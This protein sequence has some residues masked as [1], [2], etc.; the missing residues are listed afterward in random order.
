MLFESLDGIPYYYDA[1]SNGIFAIDRHTRDINAHIEAG[2]IPE[3]LIKDLLAEGVPFPVDQKMIVLEDLEKVRGM[4]ANDMRN[5][6]LNVTEECNFRCGYC[7]YSGNY[8]YERTHSGNSMDLDTAKKAIDMFASRSSSAPFRYISFYGGEPLLNLELIKKCVEYSKSIGLTCRYH[9]TTNG[10]L[11]DAAAADFLSANDFSVMVSLDG[12]KRVH[13]GYRKF[14]GGEGTYDKVFAGLLALRDRHPDFYNNKVVIISTIA[15]PYPLG[16]IYSYFSTEPLFAG[17]YIVVNFML[18]YDNSLLESYTA[19]E[20]KSMGARY[21]SELASLKRDFV[22]AA[23]AGK[24]QAHFGRYIFDHGLM[25]IQ[26][27]VMNM[28]NLNGPNGCCVPGHHRIYADRSG[29]LAPCEKC[30][31]MMRLGDID[32]GPD[33]AKSLD[34]IKRY[35]DDCSAECRD[36]YAVRFCDLC[37]VNCK[38]GDSLDFERK[39]ISCA[40]KRKYVRDCFEIYVTACERNEMAFAYLDVQLEW[41]DLA[42]GFNNLNIGFNS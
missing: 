29:G 15:P 1:N 33:P 3:S 22:E 21:S 28:S 27:R 16:E 30:C 23:A 14:A 25:N 8:R 42:E 40:E 32:T 26:N 39:K 36:C 7:V 12:P 31:R 4:L 41:K 18:P 9:V 37:F 11:L 10:S 6:I 38:R 13:D 5:L 2:T 19:E 24:A 20:K 17:K 35:A 34:F